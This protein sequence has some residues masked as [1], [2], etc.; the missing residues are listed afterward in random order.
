[1]DEN[2]LLSFNFWPSFADMILALVLVLCLALFMVAAT[3]TFGTVDLKQVESNQMSLIDAIARDYAVPY[4][5]IAEDTYGIFLTAGA[6]PDMAFH[7]DLNSQRITFSGH[8]LFE[9]D[10]VT[11]KPE[12]S[13]V[14]RRVG[15]QL[16]RQLPLIRQIQIQGHADTERTQRFA[17]N[18]ELAAER[19]IVVFDFLHQEVGIDPNVHLMSVTSFGQYLSVARSADGR[20]YDEARLYGD[21][22]TLEQRGRNRRIELLVLYRR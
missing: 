2:E 4:R 22:A 6:A 1:M 19:A 14:L 21:N 15:V 16:R 8:L 18:L 17:S 3:V 10:D 12:G 20:D 9:S 5:P 13:T 11:L 7:N